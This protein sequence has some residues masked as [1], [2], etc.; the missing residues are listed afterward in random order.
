MEV[1]NGVKFGQKCGVR[2]ERQEDL[3]LIALR[4]VFF[5]TVRIVAFDS[6]VFC[7]FLFASLFRFL[8]Q[9]SWLHDSTWDDVTIKAEFVTVRTC[10]Q[11]FLLKVSQVWTFQ[12]ENLNWKLLSMWKLVYSCWQE[13]KR[14]GKKGSKEEWEERKQ[15]GMGGKEA[16]RNGRKG[17]FCI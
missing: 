12:V 9:E 6:L 17:I 7:W 1:S 2:L 15:R 11:L 13:A 14:N 8:S 4:V 5:G 3:S 10:V 16:K